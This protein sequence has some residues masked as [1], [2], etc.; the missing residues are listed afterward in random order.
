MRPKLSL[1]SRYVVA[2]LA[3]VLIA[4]PPY[5]APSRLRA[6]G[7]GRL[8]GRAPR[9]TRQELERPDQRSA[10]LVVWGFGLICSFV[11]TDTFR[12]RRYGLVLPGPLGWPRPKA[13]GPVRAEETCLLRQPVRPGGAAAPDNALPDGADEGVPLVC[14]RRSRRR[15][16]R[17]RSGTRWGSP[18]PRRRKRRATGPGR[19]WV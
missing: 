18:G 11:A 7:R 8:G 14:R 6:L 4:G 2:V 12:A 16:A 1:T 5:A 9:L 10:V 15:A 17:T 13:A 3:L 19:Q